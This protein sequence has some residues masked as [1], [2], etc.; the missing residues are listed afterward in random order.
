MGDL[1]RISMNPSVMG[2]KTCIAGTRVT[3]GTIVGMFAAGHTLQGVLG[4]YPYLS[5]DDVRQALAYAAWR[6][7]EHDVVLA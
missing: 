4:L 2:G 1:D 6:S 7:E 3:V 5:Q